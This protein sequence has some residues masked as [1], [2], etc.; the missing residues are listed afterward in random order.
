MRGLPSTT[1]TI[2]T[3]RRASTTTR[4]SRAASRRR[5]RIPMGRATNYSGGDEMGGGRRRS[6]RSRARRRA[7]FARPRLSLGEV[8]CRV[9]WPGPILAL[10]SKRLESLKQKGRDVLDGN[11]KRVPRLQEKTA[12]RQP[13][14]TRAYWS[15]WP[16]A[17]PT[18][19]N[20]IISYS[21]G[22]ACP[23]PKCPRA[24]GRRRRRS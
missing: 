6:R 14:R 13:R 22:R 24:R 2:Y 23:C 15:S 1:S 7:R 18:L 20:V 16:S 9:P 5:R 4:T 12:G 3:E 17:T 8:L 21:S 19:S 10:R 11:N